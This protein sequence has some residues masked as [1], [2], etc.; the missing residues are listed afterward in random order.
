MRT[1]HD[2]S[3][4]KVACEEVVVCCDVFVTNGVLLRLHA[5]TQNSVHAQYNCPSVTFHCRAVAK[6]CLSPKKTLIAPPAPLH[7]QLEGM[8]TCNAHRAL[9]GSQAQ[10]M[11][12]PPVNLPYIA[13][14]A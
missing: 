1:W 12:V 11:I 10:V 9:S 8:E 13:P 3:L 5:V 14:R 2:F 6:G 7:G 4:R